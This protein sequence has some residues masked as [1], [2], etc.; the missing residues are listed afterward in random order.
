MIKM[1]SGDIVLILKKDDI[2]ACAREMG[3]PREVITDDVLDRIKQG[4]QS[5]LEGSTEVVMAAVKYGAGGGA[6]Y[7]DYAPGDTRDGRN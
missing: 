7:P 6:L 1:A 4:V 3:I 2:I 5:A